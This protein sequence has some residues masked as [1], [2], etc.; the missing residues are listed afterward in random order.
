MVRREGADHVRRRVH[1]AAHL[2]A[3]RDG[4]VPSPGPER[5]HFFLVRRRDGE[6]DLPAGL[7]GLF[8]H[9]DLVPAR[10]GEPRHLHP[11]DT[12]AEHED[13]LPLRRGFERRLGEFG[14]LQLRA[15]HGVGH[16][17]HV[18]FQRQA[19]EAHIAGDAEADRHL[20]FPEGLARPVRIG[21]ERAAERDV[22]RR[23]AGQHGLGVFR[24]QDAAGDDG[25]DA[26]RRGD[27]LRMGFQRAP[28]HGRRLDAEARQGRALIR[29]AG[30]VERRHPRRF[31]HARE[32][33]H[34]FD[35]VAVLAVL[36]AGDADPEREVGQRVAQ[37]V[38]RL[39]QQ[40]CAVRE[41][42]AVFVRPLV[43]PRCQELLEQVAI[44]GMQ[45][46]GVIACLPETPRGGDEI[47]LDLDDLGL[48]EWP[49]GIPGVG[50]VPGRWSDRFHVQHHPPQQPAAVVE[51]ADGQAVVPLDRLD[52]PRQ[53]GDE[54]VVV[55]PQRIV[56]G[57]PAGADR[58]RLRDDGGDAALRAF[59][60]I[61]AVA[62]GREAVAGA[63]VGPH[64]R[65]DEAVLHAQGTDHPRLAQQRRH[66][67]T[68]PCPRRAPPA[69]RRDRRRWRHPRA[70]TAASSA[71]GCRGSPSRGSSP[72]SSPR[73]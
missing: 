4:L 10:G 70:P 33:D 5:A 40:P 72:R 51:L 30:E 32:L 67:P 31:Q 38:H 26:H 50:V 45:F 43:D 66:A 23:A 29:P 34:L 55:D 71:P 56:V 61:G 64:R 58:H 25:G 37:P 47:L 6:V 17:G 22:V 1:A 12:G 59:L 48:V 46:D 35:R 73:A 27:R 41:A 2:H 52:Q 65:H 28:R 69:R 68:S 20:R 16:A 54:A 7:R 36:G 21:R 49:H 15:E 19:L 57:A 3:G 13:A 63:E 53:A 18:A 44:G 62:L 60:V 42:A 9:L 14:R 11:A 39:K 24:R 8:P